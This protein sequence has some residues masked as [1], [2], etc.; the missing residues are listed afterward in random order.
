MECCA[1][2]ACTYTYTSTFVAQEA[3]FSKTISCGYI[4]DHKKLLILDQ[5]WVNLYL[6]YKCIM[7][8]YGTLF[9]Y[10]QLDNIYHYRGFQCH[11]KQIEDHARV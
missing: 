6:Q 3:I 9:V 2:T 11:C 1:Y 4:G 10:R 5:L 8:V 7:Y